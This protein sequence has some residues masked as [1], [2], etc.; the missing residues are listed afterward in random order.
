M[1]MHRSTFAQLQ[2][3]GGGGAAYYCGIDGFDEYNWD[4]S[5]VHAQRQFLIPHTVLVP[6]KVL[7]EH[8]GIEG[9]MHNHIH[10]DNSAPA[11]TSFLGLTVRGSVWQDPR[12]FSSGFGGWGHPADQEQCM[13]LL[14]NEYRFDASPPT[15]Q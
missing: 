1:T 6:S 13:R 14:S 11:A 7:A 8:I 4:W 3:G 12:V 5:L 2:R 10:R 15:K 9:G